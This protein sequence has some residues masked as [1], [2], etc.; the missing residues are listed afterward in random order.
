MLFSHINSAT[1]KTLS[2]SIL[3][4][5]ALTQAIS[6]PANSV[7]CQ[8]ILETI[9]ARCFKSFIYEHTLWGTF[10]KLA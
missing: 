9:L 3:R 5:G 6:Y 4:N 10:I 8:I 2:S 7:N 1:I